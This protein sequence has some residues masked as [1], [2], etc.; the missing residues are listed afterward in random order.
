MHFLEKTHKLEI[1]RNA[2][3]LKRDS[4]PLADNRRLFPRPFLLHLPNRDVGNERKREREKKHGPIITVPLRII[5]FG[6]TREKI[7]RVTTTR[8]RSLRVT[9]FLRISYRIIPASISRRISRHAF[10][11]PTCSPPDYLTAACPREKQ[12]LSAKKNRL[13]SQH[14]RQRKGRIALRLSSAVSIDE[15]R[16]FRL[17]I[18]LIYRVTAG[19]WFGSSRAIK[20]SELWEITKFA[21]ET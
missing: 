16:K 18:Y 1:E 6:G 4:F 2:S 17:L 3:N 5:R 20:E 12:P 10:V 8:L 15:G 19:S 14:V 13:V 7:A 21:D 11:S 9:L